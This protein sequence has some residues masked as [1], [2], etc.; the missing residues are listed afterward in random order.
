MV[1]AN[2]GMQMEIGVVIDGVMMASK[3][4]SPTWRERPI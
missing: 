2:E 3:S 4:P 1:M